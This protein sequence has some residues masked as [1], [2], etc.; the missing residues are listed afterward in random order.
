ME[1]VNLSTVK[2]LLDNNVLNSTQ[3][4]LVKTLL[5][6]NF[7]RNKSLFANAII[8]KNGYEA[9]KNEWELL[10]TGL[11]NKSSVFDFEL[12]ELKDEDNV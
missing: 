7:I 3:Y 8:L 2:N 11:E 6:L 1:L 4:E 5:Q 10:L 12:Q 9:F